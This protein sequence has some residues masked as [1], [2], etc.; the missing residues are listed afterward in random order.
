MSFLKALQEDF[1]TTYDYLQVYRW[2]RVGI[3][4]CSKRL[5]KALEINS[6]AI[7]DR[8]EMHYSAGTGVDELPFPGARAIC[9]AVISDGGNNFMITHRGK[10]SLEKL[11]TRHNMITCFKELIT[12]DC[13][14]PRKPDP[15][16][17][18]YIIRKYEIPS[19]KFIAIGDRQIDIQAANSAG[20]TSCYFSQEGLECPEA[21]YRISDLAA[22][23]AIING[24]L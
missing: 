3:N 14:F 8:F 5:G 9:E 24:E 19:D 16:A 17:F 6:D 12:S 10:A 21:N 7:K 22:L 15:E 18:T 11:L 2:A 23:A 1:D 4:H 13:G 20:I